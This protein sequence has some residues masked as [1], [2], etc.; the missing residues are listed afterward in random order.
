MSKTTKNANYLQCHQEYVEYLWKAG[1]DQREQRGTIVQESERNPLL[2]KG[3]DNIVKF[4]F[5]TIDQ[6]R[7]FT[8]DG[9]EL[10]D[11]RLSGMK[12]NFSNVFYL[13]KRVSIDDARDNPYLSWLVPSMEKAY[14]YSVIL[15]DCGTIIFQPEE[16]SMTIEEYEKSLL[17][18][19][20]SGKQKTYCSTHKKD[21]S[22]FN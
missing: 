17:A 12:Y 13:V 3:R 21:V 18:K 14:T 5:Y 2:F 9:K 22:L 11:K 8:D 4:R 10:E 1:F 15:C 16:N 6:L 19:D 20:I 7:F